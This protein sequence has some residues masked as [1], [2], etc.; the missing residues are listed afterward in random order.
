M[1]EPANDRAAAAAETIRPE[2]VLPLPIKQGELA[3][4]APD[5]QPVVVDPPSQSAG[6]IALS[7]LQSP[8]A[9]KRALTV[10]ESPAG[11]FHAQ[12]PGWIRPEATRA[13][14]RDRVF[15]HHDLS[16]RQ[17]RQH[18]LRVKDVGIL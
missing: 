11:G 9:I 12:T 14:G 1:L 2:D 6:N 3:Q 13:L 8:Q 18:V 15:T 16:H 5:T 17:E 7:S 4:P 10:T